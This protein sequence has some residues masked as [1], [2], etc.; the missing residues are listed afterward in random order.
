MEKPAVV[1]LCGSTRFGDAFGQANIAE[2]L[3][4]RI[5]LSVCSTKSD[6]ELFGYLN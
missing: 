5:I 2:T 4:G 6:A 3:A 1:C